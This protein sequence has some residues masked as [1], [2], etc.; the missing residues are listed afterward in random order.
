RRKRSA[1]K[2]TWPG[3]KQVF[4]SLA[5]DGTLA[6]D[7]VSL[8][9]DPQPGKPL[10]APVMAGGRRSGGP[11]ALEAVRRYAAEELARLP[12]ALRSLDAVAPYPVEIAPA[13]AALAAVVDG[14]TA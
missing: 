5:A 9:A 4:R 10:L 12:A 1:G 3:R 11:V 8:E 13:L 6:S 7:V 14:A 2:A